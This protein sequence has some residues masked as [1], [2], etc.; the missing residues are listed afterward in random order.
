MMPMLRRAASVLLWTLAAVGVVCAG[1]WA[2]TAAGVIK[3][4]VV[5]SGSM[6]PGIMT[7]DL[8]VALPADAG[9]LAPG[10]VASL[11]SELTEH[12][13]THRIVS[14]EEE[15]SGVLRIAMKGDANEFGDM[16]DYLVP[17][18]ASVWVP[19]LTIPG[20][21][22]IVSR[23]TSP[24]VAIPLGLGLVGLIGIVWLIPPADRRPSAPASVH[25]NP[26]GSPA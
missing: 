1:V 11:P 4:L 5:I 6:E 13:V 8:L 15:S 14:I 22:E 9:D 19:R 21:G 25:A 23:L 16:L 17:A 12:L 7:G 10:Q 26:V 18:D 2:A 24:A 3:P 20:A